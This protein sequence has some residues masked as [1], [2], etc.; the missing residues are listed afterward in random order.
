M[1]REAEAGG[2]PLDG[3]P[4]EPDED[5][6]PE[7]S[8]GIGDEE[9]A[10]NNNVEKNQEKNKTPEIKVDK[11][12]AVKKDPI[13]VNNN[14]LPGSISNFFMDYDTAEKDIEEYSLEFSRIL[15]NMAGNLSEK[16]E[17]ETINDVTAT[18]IS[19][20]N[21]LKRLKKENRQSP[22]SLKQNEIRETDRQIRII[23]NDIRNG[24]IFNRYHA[25]K[26]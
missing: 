26:G 8:E 15:Q 1:D 25:K 22:S 17:R 16:R 3:A 12:G 11:I 6:P 13:D 18:L 10:V 14:N 24:D 5:Q 2:V 9:K 7:E 21:E 23:I 4:P 19:Y 20:S